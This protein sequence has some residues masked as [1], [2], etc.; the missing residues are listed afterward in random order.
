MY[1]PMYMQIRLTSRFPVYDSV[2]SFFEGSNFPLTSIR[3]SWDPS[4]KR[5]DLIFR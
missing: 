1:L 4:N 5:G 2:I 3:V